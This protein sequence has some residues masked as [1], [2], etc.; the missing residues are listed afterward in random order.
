VIRP[1]PVVLLAALTLAAPPARVV[2]TTPS[3][4]EILFALGLGSRVAGVTTY[5]R[6]PPEAT[7]LPKVGTYIQPNL[8]TIASL[9]PDLVV[10]QKNPIQ[11]ADKLNRLGLRSLELHHDSVD[12]VYTS[13]ERLAAAMGESARGRQLVGTLRSRLQKVRDRTAR[14]PRRKVA[15]IVGRRA[16]TI[17]GLFSI[18]KATYLNDLIEI[19]GGQGV[20]ADAIAPYPKVTLEELLS[21]NPDV[22]I[23][24]GDM[25]EA[26]S[27]TDSQRQAVVALWQRYPMLSAVKNKR[28]YAVASDIF[29]VPGPR[30]AEAAE[31]FAEMLHRGELK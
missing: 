11:L 31:A 14:F 23:D 13:I 24:M 25:A 21:R 19:A 17:E 15:F 6:Y 7:R 8:E 5:C 4:T 18:G 27:L 3:I 30:M 28:V 26:A 20:F 10:I 16:G 12:E 9:R 1:L 2:S 22:I 29:V